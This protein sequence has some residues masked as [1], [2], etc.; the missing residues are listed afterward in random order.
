MKFRTRI[1]LGYAA[2]ALAISLGL[3]MF[4]NMYIIQ[5]YETAAFNQ[6]GILSEQMLNNL[7][8]NIQKMTQVTLSL[9]SDQD[10]VQT[11]RELSV[12]MADPEDYMADIV[13]GKA[14]LKR[15][16]Y[17][18]YNLENFYRVVVFNRYGYIAAS[19][20]MQERLVN[21]EKD[22]SEIPWLGEVT[23]TKGRSILVG[24]HPDDWGEA[25]SAPQ[26]YSLVREIQG[27]HL[28]FIEV[29]I[30]KKDFG[31]IFEVSDDTIKVIAVKG[32][33]D[34]LY[35]SEG[36]EAEKYSR[37]FADETGTLKEKSPVSGKT[38]LV[39]IGKSE[40]SGVRLILIQDRKAAMADMPNA[41][42]AAMGVAVLVFLPSL[43]FI[44]FMAERLT[45][46]MQALR[47]RMEKTELSNLTE[48][49]TIDSRDEDINALTKAYQD[50]MF[51]LD[52]SLNVEKKLNL[53]QLQAQ[54][55]TL[56]AQ[57]NPHFLYNV[58]N[59]ISSRGMKDN[60]E[61]ICEICGRLAD[62]LRYSTNTK[63]RYDSI[64]EEVAYT[65]QYLYLIKVR[66]GDKISLDTEIDSGIKA[67][68]VPKTVL[69]QI[70]ENSINH[71]FE[72]NT[73]GMKMSVRG[74]QE[75]GRWFLSVRDNGQGFGEETLRDLNEKFAR[76]K[77]SLFEDR[78][79][80]ELEIGGM[81][82]V[83]TYA[84]LLLI[85]SDSLVFELKNTEDG[86]EVLFGAKM[87]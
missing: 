6:F 10:A 12:D 23:G 45:R 83:N 33:G 44:F 64:A 28:G 16:L 21:A 74:Y 81:G 13:N 17:T 76:T 75:D 14:R 77:K 5:K 73:G 27:D 29:Q 55:D 47:R 48:E 62:M 87:S 25:D 43:A 46:P 61:T 50:L 41:W 11:I 78:S 82:L 65:E 66:Y 60:D 56:Q 2:L 18:A 31:E 3:G 63:T 36:T 1:T 54:F 4:Y 42:A 34:I 57:I 39:S 32:N 26:V 22:V 69:Q 71:G 49:I 72:N 51:R 85:Y 35:A 20:T 58:L 52:H 84:R 37:L 53:L 79:N 7:D 38:E 9:L 86:A 15:D 24:E 67:Q 80:I 59:V 30:L 70:V 40:E 68:I 8:E 19:A